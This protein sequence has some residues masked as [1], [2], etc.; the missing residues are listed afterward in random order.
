M[1]YVLVMLPMVLSALNALAL[2]LEHVP[3]DKMNFDTQSQTRH[4]RDWV[5]TKIPSKSP[6]SITSYRLDIKINNMD[7]KKFNL[8][9]FRFH[10]D[11]IAPYYPEKTYKAE[12]FLPEFLIS[13]T[14]P[15]S[16][17]RLPEASTLSSTA[18]WL[19]WRS[20]NQ[21]GYLKDSLNVPVS[22]VTPDVFE[23]LMADFSQEVNP[24]LMKTG[25]I[26][27][28]YGT[29]D[30]DQIQTAVASYLYVGNGI[31]LEAK[32]SK[33]KNYSKFVYLK[34]VQLHFKNRLMDYR[35][36]SFRALTKKS[37]YLSEYV[38]DSKDQDLNPGLSS[39][40]QAA[41][42]LDGLL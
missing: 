35:L 27:V 5:V 22:E 25:D 28:V 38:K 29:D 18:H 12:N 11:P 4:Y 23:R 9:N 15:E 8:Y 30:I 19:E 2:K 14:P 26:V 10:G 42:T 31:V 21:K 7:R 33:N 37:L 17:T 24:E 36:K 16:K 40:R 6:H 32:K 3:M 1:K 39:D 20:G 34:D 13:R 41:K